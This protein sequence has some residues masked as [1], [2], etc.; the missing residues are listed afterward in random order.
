MR[1]DHL[2]HRFGVSTGSAGLATRI[3]R[4]A[5]VALVLIIG[6]TGVI[7][8]D[9]DEEDSVPMLVDFGWSNPSG[10]AFIFS[11]RVVAQNPGSL[12]VTFGG[13]LAGHTTTTAADGSF[14]FGIYLYPDDYGVATA[15]SADQIGTQTNVAQTIVY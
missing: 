7:K 13:I 15:Q 14:S 10:Q 12:T 9:S 6:S 1:T 8:A 11:G 3:G 4:L 5:A 2:T